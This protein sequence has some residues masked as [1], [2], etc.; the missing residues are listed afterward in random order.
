MTKEMLT[1]PAIEAAVLGPTLLGRSATV[2][3]ISNAVV[4]LASDESSYVDG[5][6]LVVDGGYTSA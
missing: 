5:S 3:E 4:F 1:D 2:S 6:E